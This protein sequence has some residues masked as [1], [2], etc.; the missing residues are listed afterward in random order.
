MEQQEHLAAIAGRFAQVA[1]RNWARLVGNWEATLGEDGEPVLNYLTLAV[2]D[3]G[4]RWL[5]GQVGYDEPLYDLV[6]AYNNAS[7]GDADAQVSSRWTVLDLEV[8]EDGT[9]RTNLGYG[10]PKR[11][12]GIMDEESLGRFESY[13]DTWVTEHGTVPGG[14]S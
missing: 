3:G 1:P 11:S 10:Q 13:L 4:D 2:V 8:D 6:A 7:S 5:F 12:N 14:A 9:F